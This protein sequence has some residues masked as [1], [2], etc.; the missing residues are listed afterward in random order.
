MSTSTENTEQQGE[1]KPEQKP[2]EQSPQGQPQSE[3]RS[4]ESSRQ[5]ESQGEQRPAGPASDIDWKAK[6][7]HEEE[8]ARQSTAEIEKLKEQ[9]AEAAE[10]SKRA[11]ELEQKVAERDR[12]LLR[13]RIATE[14]G[15]PHLAD[16]L[17]GETE[18]EIA[19]DAKSLISGLA[20][21]LA[22]IGIGQLGTTG[23]Q[24]SSSDDLA[25][26]LQ[27]MR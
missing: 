6:A 27:K 10:G 20:N 11:Q 14:A 13:Y 17:R 2:V 18:E 22:G 16:R 7:R 1:Q 3:Q 4:T 9:L 8:R 25:D 21:P 15:V 24:A 23:P 26:R 19:Q 12:T 5:Q